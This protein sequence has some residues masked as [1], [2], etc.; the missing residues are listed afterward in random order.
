MNKNYTDHTTFIHFQL[1]IE[2]KQYVHYRIWQIIETAEV[3]AF[4]VKWLI[5]P[6]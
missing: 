5:T 3:E 6:G 2:P 1:L 4:T